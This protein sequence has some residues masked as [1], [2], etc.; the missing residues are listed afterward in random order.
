MATQ[1]VLFQVRVEGVPLT[2]VMREDCS[3]LVPIRELDAKVIRLTRKNGDERTE[4]AARSN[5]RQ[6]ILTLD[7]QIVPAKKEEI[8]W[9]KQCEVVGKRAPSCSLLPSEGAVLSLEHFGREAFA[10]QFRALLQRY[11]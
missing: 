3:V 8:K 5:V 7:I 1:S 11:V 9:L 4:Q 10:D 2:C 6:H